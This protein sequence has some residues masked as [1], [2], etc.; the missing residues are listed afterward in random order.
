[1]DVTELYNNLFMKPDPAFPSMATTGTPS[2][3]QQ[4]ASGLGQN[5]SKPVIMADVGPYLNAFFQAQT[6]GNPNFNS[7]NTRNCSLPNTFEG[8]GA[9][10][11]IAASQGPLLAFGQGIYKHCC[12]LM[13][14]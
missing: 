12:L 1:M 7:P 4:L 2:I 11:P 9:C 6:R 14:V 3:Q 10:L 8:S 5:V 13:V